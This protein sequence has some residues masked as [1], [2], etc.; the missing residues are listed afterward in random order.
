MAEIVSIWIKRAH[1]QPMKRVDQA[2]LVAGR[3]L[4][5]NA[6]QG[7]WRQVTIIDEDA[8][9]NATEELGVD[10]DPSARRA[11]VMIRGLDLEGSRGRKLIL[12]DC[13]INIRGENPPCRLMDQMQ[14]FLKPHWRAGIFGEIVEGGTIRAGDEVAFEGL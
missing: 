8:W 13:V 4:V 1:R 3:G 2:E 14:K 11:N 10:V 12:G 5:G 9:R 6:D 7:G